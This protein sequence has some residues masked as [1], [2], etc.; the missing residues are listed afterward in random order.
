MWLWK[1]AEGY[2]SKLTVADKA[3]RY[4]EGISLRY[5]D[6]GFSIGTV[7]HRVIR[8]FMIQVADSLPT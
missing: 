1:R 5:V 4:G 8:D 6:D 2:R 3:P 7:F